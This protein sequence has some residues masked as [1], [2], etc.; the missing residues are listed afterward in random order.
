MEMTRLFSLPPLQSRINHT[1]TYTGITYA[2]GYSTI[3]RFNSHVGLTTHF[4]DMSAPAPSSKT[5]SRDLSRELEEGIKPWI[6]PSVFSTTPSSPFNQPRSRSR[7]NSSQES[8]DQGTGSSSSPIDISSAESSPIQVRRPRGIARYQSPLPAT[9]FTPPRPSHQEAIHP[10]FQ[11]TKSLPPPPSQRPRL[12][13]HYSST[14]SSSQ[15]TETT[16]TQS[17]FVDASSEVTDR[18]TRPEAVKESTSAK[19]KGKEKAK[20]SDPIPGFSDAAI[21]AIVNEFANVDIGSSRAK[22]IA[23]SATSTKSELPKIRSNVKPSISTIPSISSDPSGPSKS[24]P[25]GRVV[26]KP[27]T[28]SRLPLIPQA[29]PSNEAPPSKPKPKSRS[30]PKL[31]DPSI[32]YFNY[33]KVSN[34][35]AVVYTTDPDEVNDLIGCLKGDVFGF[36]LEWPPMVKTY[37]KKAKAIKFGQGKTALIQICD[38]DTVL[39][40]HMKTM[41]RAFSFY[42]MQRWS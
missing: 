26:P 35:P 39:L 31:D 40:I 34:P 3:R 10:F 4:R 21:D 19:G 29:P 25:K 13:A 23:A 15:Q 9:A 37:D 5:K 28:Y 33:L 20:T 14:E 17:T 12:V 42:L 41:T 27:S 30:R 32:E 24:Y 1:Y 16:D 36:D 38:R 8:Q 2:R 11:R 7:Q 6:G 22:P 18:V